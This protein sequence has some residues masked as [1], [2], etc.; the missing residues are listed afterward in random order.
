[1]FITMAVFASSVH[2]IVYLF[3]TA[4]GATIA[5]M[6]IFSLMVILFAGCGYLATR[7]KERFSKLYLI[8]GCALCWLGFIPLITVSSGLMALGSLSQEE[9]V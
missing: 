9:L 1:M 6:V 4:S 5:F 7:M 2:E 3:I 8:Y